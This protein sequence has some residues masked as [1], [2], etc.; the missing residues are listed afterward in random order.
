MEVKEAIRKRRAYRSLKDVTITEEL[1]EDLVAGYSEE[2][3]KEILHIPEDMRVITLVV[4]S[5][6]EELN[7]VLTENQIHS[8]MY[9]PDR[10]PLRKFIYLRKYEE[11]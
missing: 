11:V 7:P 3:V 10:L 1:T 8:E 6:S 2:Q 9:R 4:V 5:H